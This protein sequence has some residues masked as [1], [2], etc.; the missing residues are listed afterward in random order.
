MHPDDARERG[1]GDGGAVRISSSAGS[2][3]VP[4]AVTADIVSGVVSLPHGY[5]HQL[6]G[7]R[8]GIAAGVAGASVNDVV[9]CEVEG[10]SG[11]A[12]LNGVAVR[13]EAA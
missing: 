1:L 3:V 13:V 12:V 11:N 4:L 9:A 8:L 2:V 7:V 5:G 10:P 6:T